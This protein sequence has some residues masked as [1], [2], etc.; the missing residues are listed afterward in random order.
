MPLSPHMLSKHG[1]RLKSHLR[2]PLQRIVFPLSS[3]THSPLS[4]YCLSPEGTKIFRNVRNSL[5]NYTAH[6]P[7]RPESSATLQWEPQI[8]Q[9]RVITIHT[10]HMHSVSSLTP[11]V[12]CNDW[13][14]KSYMPTSE[15]KSY[16]NLS[17]SHCFMNTLCASYNKV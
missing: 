6:H 4:L 12:V 13:I 7:R 15:I 8:L 1:W 2:P 9:N 16:W 3:G 5:P 11:T 10:L 17:F 14:L